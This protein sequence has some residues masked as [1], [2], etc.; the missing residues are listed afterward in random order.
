MFGRKKE[1]KSSK[2]DISNILKAWEY[3]IRQ[4]MMVRRIQGKNGRTKIQ[5]RLDLGILQME[6]EGRPDGK[7]PHGKE[8][9]LEYF[10][11]AAA[12]TRK[13]QKAEF[14]FSLDKEDCYALQQE[15]IQYYYRYLCFFQLGDYRRAERDTA[16]N[17]RLFDFVKKYASDKQSVEEFEQYR[18]YV[19]MMN[20]RAKVL[21]ALKSKDARQAVNEIHQGIH[22]IENVYGKR[23]GA[24]GSSRTEVAFL[25][26]WAEEIIRSY[27]PSRKQR[28]VEELR[29]AVENEEY[30]R[31]ARI[32]DKLNRMKD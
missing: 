21:G 27:T 5:M 25:K 17:L 4:D 10:E 8:S 28:L 30:E 26:N 11:S 6:E 15:G 23:G 16:R 2:Y 12:R 19:M 22:K 20:T 24:S 31:A 7:R 13:K 18:T 14:S 1:G 29:I 3:D 32:R 9:L